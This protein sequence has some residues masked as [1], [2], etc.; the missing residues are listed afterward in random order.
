MIVSIFF[1]TYLFWLC[2]VFMPFLQLQQAA[3]ALSLRCMGFWRQ[4]LLV[5]EHGLSSAR[6]SVVAAPGVWST[7]SAAVAH[8]L[9]CSKVCRI[10]P[11]QG[12]NL[13]LLHWQVA[14]GAALL[15]PSLKVGAGAQRAIV[16][17]TLSQT[18]FYCP[19][20][21]ILIYQGWIFSPCH[22]LH[23]PVNSRT[24]Q[25]PPEIRSHADHACPRESVWL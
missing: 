5:A 19:R 14:T 24:L 21:Q 4:G 11:D 25:L 15:A 8:R 17:G 6:A 18:W 7:V 20:T 9:A 13:C 12:W 22:S 1:L 16:I 2:W 23:A 3:A 10:F